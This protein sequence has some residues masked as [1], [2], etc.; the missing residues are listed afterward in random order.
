[1]VTLIFPTR[2]RAAGSEQIRRRFLFTIPNSSQNKLRRGLFRDALGF[3]MFCEIAK[4]LRSEGFDVTNVKPGKACVAS[5]EVKFPEFNVF[6]ML[7]TRPRHRLIRCRVSTWC[8]RPIWRRVS[9]E[10]V[11]KGWT[12]VCA[13][14]ERILSGD[15]RVTSLRCLS[16]TESSAVANLRE[17]TE[18]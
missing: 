9:P 3:G 10:T 18:E 15:S 11:S 13:A 4:Q 14:M 12:R 17:W 7:L 5:F 6:A 2:A 8:I 16:E 1:M